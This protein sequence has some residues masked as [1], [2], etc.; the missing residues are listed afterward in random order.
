V[1]EELVQVGPVKAALAG[2]DVS[3]A[4]QFC[5][6]ALHLA[7]RASEIDGEG[8]EGREARTVDPGIPSQPP[9]E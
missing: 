1:P 4:N 6:V 2:D 3:G 7:F 5:D 9:P 8:R